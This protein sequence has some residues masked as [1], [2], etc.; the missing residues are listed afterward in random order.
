MTAAFKELKESRNHLISGISGD[1]KI[2]LFQEKHTEVVDQYFRGSLENST[3]GKGLF[4]K[5]IPFA[6]L[7]VGGYGRRELSLCSDVD[8]LIL[9]NA[10][11]PRLAKEL[12]GE[13]FYP[14]WDLGL[15][16]GHGTRTIRDCLKLCNNDFQVL[17]S[18]MDSRF[19]CGDSPLY[20]DLKKRLRQKIIPKK[21]VE[22]SR[23]RPRNHLL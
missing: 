13:I 2:L 7:A 1:A 8:V 11:I 14:L 10:K 17:T 15:D 19:I 6:F 16:L 4:K 9:F 23:C 3:A 22:F 18:L 21:A 20:L 12:A 5:R